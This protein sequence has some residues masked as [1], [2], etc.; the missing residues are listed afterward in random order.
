HRRVDRG[1][2]TNRP[3]EV[4]QLVPARGEEQDHEEDACEEDQCVAVPF[5]EGVHSHRL[6]STGRGP[7]SW[8]ASVK[9]PV[10]SCTVQVPCPS[11]RRGERPL[12]RLVM[13]VPAATIQEPWDAPAPPS[14]LIDTPLRP[15]I[16]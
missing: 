7:Q 9:Y 4:P 11:P 15:P 1:Q 10:K 5:N 16:A 8:V 6:V 13:G 14:R 2:V 3:L 12:R